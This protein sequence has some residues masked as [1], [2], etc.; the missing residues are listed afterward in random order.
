MTLATWKVFRMFATYLPYVDMKFRSLNQ[1]TCMEQ[2]KLSQGGQASS[3]PGATW[4]KS[5]N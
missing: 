5:Q 2:Q 3:R 4:V 1:I